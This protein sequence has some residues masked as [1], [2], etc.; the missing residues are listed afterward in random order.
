MRSRL[1]LSAAVI[2]TSCFEPL[3]RVGDDGES[4][5]AGGS[6]GGGGGI[7]CG[8]GLAVC[9]GVCVNLRGDD[10]SCGACGRGC[11]PAESCAAGSCHP[12][13]C[14]VADCSAEQVCDLDRCTDKECV[15]VACPAGM[16]CFRGV[17]LAPSCG[18]G[19]AC[20]PG[21]YCHAGQCIDPGCLGV[22]CPAPL[23]CIAGRC[24]D[25][26][27]GAQCTPAQA[28]WLG[29]AS[30]DP[31]TCTARQ[32]KAPGLSCGAGSVCDGDGGCNRCDAGQAC[33][34]PGLSCFAGVI[35]CATGAPVCGSLA[36]LP[37][38]TS[39]PGGTCAADG[40]CD[41]CLPGA[42]CAAEGPCLVGAVSCTDAGATC[43]ASGARPAGSSCA[44]DGGSGAVCGADGGCNA[45]TP[46][47]P[48]TPPLVCMLG[49]VSCA[50]GEPVCEPTVPE[51]GA[52]CD[53]GYCR[54]DAGC[55][56]CVAGLP[57]STGNACERGVTD[58][59]G[60]GEQRCIPMG[61]LPAATVCRA[62]AGV[63]DRAETCDGVTLACPADA[64]LAAGTACGSADASDCNA[65]DSCD[66]V[67]NACVDRV[68][69]ST[70]V[71]RAA[72]AGNDAVCNPAET[73]TGASPVCPADVRAQ[74]GAACGSADATACNAADSCDGAGTCVDRV[75]AAG[76]VCRAAVGTC[77]P[78]ESCSGS[79]ASCPADAKAAAG[80]A[81]GSADATACNAA[82]SCDGA[83]SCVDRLKAAG[84]VCRVSA[85]VCD[86]AESCSGSSAA[87]PAD[88]KA[89]A[90]TAC[91]SADT[92]GCNAA[93]SCDGMSNGCVDRVKAA[94]TL[95]RAS[96]GVC[97]PA[98]SCT[99]A[100]ATCPA[101]G[102]LAAGT[103]CGSQSNA[104]CDAPDSCDGTGNACVARFKPATAVCRA[105]GSGNDAVCNPPE[106]C[107]GA[108]TACPADYRRPVADPCPGGVCSGPSG[109]CNPCTP[110]GACNP[111]NDCWTGV[112]SCNTGAAVCS[113]TGY[114]PVFSPCGSGQLCNGTGTCCH[115]SWGGYSMANV[116]QSANTYYV[117]RGGWCSFTNQCFQ[118]QYTHSQSIRSQQ[119]VQAG[120]MGNCTDDDALWFVECDAVVQCQYACSGVCVPTH[121]N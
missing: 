17:C 12:D 74:A 46:G 11:G 97:D 87:C 47:A 79:S 70:V 3:V 54:A 71:C 85:G 109:V 121:C 78:A 51:T 113:V 98:E 89:A 117:F 35:G 75:K 107:T 4:G 37:E 24:D 13:D 93:D 22:T 18:D 33:S 95:C 27:P 108:S 83:G 67:S 72:G 120:S 60:T 111:G 2:I 50:T 69:P 38:G 32:P 73:C 49:Q 82:D 8:A 103:A 101:D 105:G 15:G 84:A 42:V 80:T 61:P 7:T 44:A 58:C 52:A 55:G 94:G 118:N 77:D 20:P 14:S 36:P 116:V 16:A 39:C 86:P 26:S 110:G 63:C 66:G 88:A 9:D 29:E 34:V 28:C 102:K 56:A 119:C 91:G 10:S 104:D 1:V 65:A 64:K 59:M 21:R 30:C 112:E 41:L 19:G 5:A 62:A 6:G 57:C 90:G 23:V 96:A 115:Q 76:T 81:C 68:K 100:S 40:G 25:C 106:T 53:G 92:S 114:K 48:C 31:T 99:G 45:C 43:V